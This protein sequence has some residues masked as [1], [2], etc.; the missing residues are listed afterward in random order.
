MARYSLTLFMLLVLT[1]AT[2]F[3]A[4]NTHGPSAVDMEFKRRMGDSTPSYVVEGCVHGTSA[5]TTVSVPAC[6]AYA[7]DTS[8]GNRLEFMREASARNITYSGGD[9]LYWLAARHDIK[10]VPGGWTCVP[11]SHYCWTLNANRPALPDGMTFL[12][13]ATVSGG[14]ITEVSSLSP[15]PSLATVTVDCPTAID[16]TSQIQAAVD[17]MPVIGGNVLLS[18]RCVVTDEIVIAKSSVTIRGV[19]T[20]G[21]FRGPADTDKSDAGAF[22]VVGADLPNAIFRFTSFNGL[23]TQGNTLRDLTIFGGGE[24]TSGR[25]YDVADAA[26]YVESSDIFTMDNV[27]IVGIKGRALWTKRSVRSVFKNLDITFSGDTGLSPVV[28]G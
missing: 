19:G 1:V 11:G 2:G 17:R 6:D 26:V 24:P 7:M 23:A 12:S 22:I 14:A 21:R 9:G 10:V 3:A 27:R 4:S 8:D 15:L 20:S 13:F 5:T 28:I 18:G 25:E 16:N